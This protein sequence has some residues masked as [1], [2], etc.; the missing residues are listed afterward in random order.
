[1]SGTAINS[2]GGDITLTSGA[3][4]TGGSGTAGTGGVISLNAAT[5]SSNGL[6]LAFPNTGTATIVSGSSQNLTIGA[7]GNT[8]TLGSSVNFANAKA[9]VNTNGQFT[10]LGNVTTVGNGVVGIVYNTIP[11]ATNANISATTM[12]TPGA[13]GVYEAS[14]YVT[15]V[16]VGTGCSVTGATLGVNLI[17]NDPYSG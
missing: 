3:A 9:A 7:G 2:N 16:D 14:F 5:I 12:L 15:Q 8:I 1:S 17:Y 10:K 11:A 4:G 6:T 13:D